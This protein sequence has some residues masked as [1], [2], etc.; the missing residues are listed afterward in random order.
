MVGASPTAIAVPLERDSGD[1]C[2]ATSDWVG[3]RLVVRSHRERLKPNLQATHD[4]SWVPAP[5][6]PHTEQRGFCLSTSLETSWPH[7]MMNGARG[8]GLASI[9]RQLSHVKRPQP[10]GRPVT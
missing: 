5:L 7:L 10:G 4:G 9:E 6:C 3:C 2:D 8:N 1:K